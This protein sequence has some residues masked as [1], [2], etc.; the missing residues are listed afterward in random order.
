MFDA[1]EEQDDLGNVTARANGMAIDE[2]EDFGEGSEMMG[3]D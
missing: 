3:Q 2:D 1:S